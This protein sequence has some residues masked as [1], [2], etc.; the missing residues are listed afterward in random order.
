MKCSVVSGNVNVNVS[1]VTLR[2]RECLTL[3]TEILEHPK[4]KCSN[5][6]I[7]R[8]AMFSINFLG[9]LHFS[10][11]HIM[12]KYLNVMSLRPDQNFT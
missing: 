1:A 4:P 3:T 7:V 10:M 12:V 2:S 11:V 9:S 5:F 6:Q 8:A